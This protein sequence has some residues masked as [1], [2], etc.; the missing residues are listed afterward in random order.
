MFDIIILLA[1]NDVNTFLL[2]LVLIFCVECIPMIKFAEAA[3]QAD[4]LLLC[5]P[6]LRLPLNVFKFSHD[7]EVLIYTIQYFCDFTGMEKEQ[8]I[9]CGA[10]DEMVIVGDTYLV[11]YDDDACLNRQRWSVAHELG[12]IY[13]RHDCDSSDNEIEAHQF[14]AE[15][16]MPEPVIRDL[17]KRCTLTPWQLSLI[18]GVSREAM[19]KR[20]DSLSRGYRT[21]SD[22][23]DALAKRML[24]EIERVAE[25]YLQSR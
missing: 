5:Q 23:A 3:R 11:L 16:L 12:H 24:P 21:H 17:V 25:R 13:M 22:L 15:V 2:I 1:R 7:R 6:E 10:T 20:L 18:F 14:A 19:N 4:I 9:C 8:M